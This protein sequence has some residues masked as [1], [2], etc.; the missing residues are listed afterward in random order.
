MFLIFLEFVILDILEESLLYKQIDEIVPLIGYNS[1]NEK[2][3]CTNLVHI[4]PTDI[5]IA[6]AYPLI[7]FTF[8]FPDIIPRGSYYT[9]SFHLK[10]NIP[11]RLL[12][13]DKE[14][15]T[16]RPVNWEKRIFNDPADFEFSK[17]NE[18]S[19]FEFA[20]TLR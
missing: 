4:Q 1:C 9:F 20:L 3:V 14:R 15:F 10:K 17:N 18:S 8:S 13:E 16:R 12:L 5:Y 2:D 6:F 7:K 11:C 19:V